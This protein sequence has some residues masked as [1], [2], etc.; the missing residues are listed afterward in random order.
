MS[1][2]MNLALEAAKHFGVPSLVGVTA[3]QVFDMVKAMGKGED[4]FAV[5][6]TLYQ[7][8]AG[9]IIGTPDASAT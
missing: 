9:V 7:E 1:K 8:I 3:G 4:D 6:A 5:I 2:D